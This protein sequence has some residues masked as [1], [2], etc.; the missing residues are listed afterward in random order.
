MIIKSLHLIRQQLN[1]F[2]KHAHLLEQVS[3]SIEPTSSI[4]TTMLLE[5]FLSYLIFKTCLSF[6][7]FMIELL[8]PVFILYSLFSGRELSA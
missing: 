4:F 8:I 5:L 1:L 6:I 3:N 7:L 2:E